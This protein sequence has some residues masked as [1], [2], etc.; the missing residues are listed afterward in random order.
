MVEGE[1][2]TSNIER[3]NVYEGVGRLIKDHSVSLFH[4]IFLKTTVTQKVHANK[5]H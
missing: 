2:V 1:R 4:M 5:M 3:E